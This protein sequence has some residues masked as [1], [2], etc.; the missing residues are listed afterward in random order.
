MAWNFK[1]EF[2]GISSQISWYN[3]M[4]LYNNYAL[5]PILFAGNDSTA[6]YSG[7]TWRDACYHRFYAQPDALYVA[8]W[9][10][11]N[12]ATTTTP[13]MAWNFECTYPMMSTQQA[14]Y[15]TLKHYDN[16]ALKPILFG[17]NDSTAD[18]SGETWRDPC[19]HRFYAQNATYVIYWQV[20]NDATTPLAWNFRTLFPGIGT[21]QTWYDKF[22]YY[23]N[24]ALKPIL[25]AGNDSTADYSGET[26]RDPCYH[27]LYAQPNATFVVYWQVE[28]DMYCEVMRRTCCLTVTPSFEARYLTRVEMRGDG[29]AL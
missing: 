13:P 6:D 5:K 29:C 7:E 1:T 4:K 11:E 19:Y 3:A 24:F 10:V 17:G 26:W 23:D 22:Q 16:F 20:E 21:Q 9:L 14:S 12:D 25:F 28:N 15:N 27:R 18:Y 2:P 8:Y